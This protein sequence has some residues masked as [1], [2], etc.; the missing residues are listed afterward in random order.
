MT[1]ELIH[2]ELN[3]EGRTL[4]EQ[5]LALVVTDPPSFE[6]AGLFLRT[7]KEYLKRVDEVFQ[8]IVQKAHAAWKEAL[9][10]KQKLETPALEAERALK[11]TRAAWDEKQRALIR[12]AEAQA[13]QERRR[14]EDEAKLQAALE[15]ESRGDQEGAARILEAPAPPVPIIVPM[16]VTP[17]LPKSEGSSFRTYYRAEVTD[18][19]ALI[20]AVAAGTASMT[21]L[22]PNM[23]ALNGS[24]RALKEELKVPGVR[25]IL[26]RGEAVRV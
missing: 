11:A 1:Q 5:A 13:A 4:Q 19:R 20:V 22:Q 6:R 23:V 2:Q 15:A 18:L 10:Q 14:L 26:E 16:A 25:V 7:V 12:E 3:A 9:G 21:Y 8:P 24:A 17:T